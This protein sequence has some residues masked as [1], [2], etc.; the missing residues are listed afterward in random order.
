MRYASALVIFVSCSSGNHAVPNDGATD[1][2]SDADV[3]AVAVPDEPVS[4]CVTD[5]LV[6]LA[7]DGTTPWTLTGTTG[8]RVGSGSGSSMPLVET[9]YILRR[10]SGHC[11]FAMSSAGPITQVDSSGHETVTDTQVVGMDSGETPHPWS[12]SFQ[13]CVRS[14]DQALHYQEMRS[15]SS[16]GGPEPM[17]T[18]TDGVLTH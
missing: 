3:C 7:F 9:M 14:T 13:L 2:A 11:A 6:G 18:T 15:M 8:Y 4:G 1:V 5:G 17:V 10:G 12:D 16:T